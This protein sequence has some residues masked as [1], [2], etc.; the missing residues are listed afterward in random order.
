ML[1]KYS[2]YLYKSDFQQIK[3]IYKEVCKRL[4]F[5]HADEYAEN[6]IPPRNLDAKKSLGLL[7]CKRNLHFPPEE[8]TLC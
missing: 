7:R 6:K 1:V 4:K 5:N 3:M 8:Q 2:V